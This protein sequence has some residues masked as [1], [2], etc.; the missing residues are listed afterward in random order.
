MCS[1]GTVQASMASWFRA[2]T[3]TSDSSAVTRSSACATCSRLSTPR[4]GHQQGTPCVHPRWLTSASFSTAKGI[5]QVKE[6]NNQRQSSTQRALRVRNKQRRARA[7]RLQQHRLVRELPRPA[8]RQHGMS[9]CKHKHTQGSFRFFFGRVGLFQARLRALLLRMAGL[10]CWGWQDACAD[11]APQLLV[12]C[13]QLIDLG[14][15][16]LLQ[17]SKGALTGHGNWALF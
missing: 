7:H 13:L 15:V 1:C 17:R 2:N 16:R 14:G 8:T 11:L 6:F 4:G 12:A 10:F 5:H 3:D 9:G